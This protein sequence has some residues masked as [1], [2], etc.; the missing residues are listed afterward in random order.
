M[1]LPL[2][3]RGWVAAAICRGRRGGVLF[4]RAGDPRRAHRSIWFALTF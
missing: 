4:S 3:V 2:T 1:R